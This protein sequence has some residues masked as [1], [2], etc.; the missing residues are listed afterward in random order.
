MI[1]IILSTFFVL[2]GLAALACLA[3]SAIRAFNHWRDL[4][5]GK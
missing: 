2:V 5:K 3:D 1:D 4:N